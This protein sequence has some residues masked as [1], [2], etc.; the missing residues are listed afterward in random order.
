MAATVAEELGSDLLALRSITSSNAARTLK[1]L[2]DVESNSS[3][4]LTG[5]VSLAVFSILKFPCICRAII[6]FV[7]FEE[8]QYY[9]FGR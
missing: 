3:Q 9:F 1:E 4:V 6:D 7:H 5:C 2:R 8:T